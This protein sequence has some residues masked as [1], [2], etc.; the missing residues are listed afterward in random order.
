VDVEAW[1]KT[2]R[3]MRG[4]KA[5]IRNMSADYE[6]VDHAEQDYAVMRLKDALKNF[7]PGHA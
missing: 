7:G 5:K 4:T 6:N 2:L 3:L 1:L